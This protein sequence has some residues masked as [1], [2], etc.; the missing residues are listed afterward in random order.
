MK[1]LLVAGAAI[2]L[3]LASPLASAAIVD[4]TDGTYL[5]DTSAGLDWLDV[6]STTGLSFNFVTSQFGSGG[7]FSG[8]RHATRD[9]FN[10]LVG[11]FTGTTI[12]TYLRVTQ[13]PDLIDGLV[14]LLGSSIDVGWLRTYGVTWDAYHGFREGEGFDMSAGVLAELN[15]NDSNENVFAALWDDDQPNGQPDYSFADYGHVPKWYAPAEIGHFLVRT[16]G[17]QPQLPVSEPGTLM[18]VGSSLALLAATLRRRVRLSV[19]RSNAAYE[20]SPA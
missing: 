15:P 18:L 10:Q 16:S 6:T 8:W 17:S 20:Q 19:R 12:N 9:E 13:E 1:T 14:V 4:S 2:A 11:N 5:T 7:A 3:S